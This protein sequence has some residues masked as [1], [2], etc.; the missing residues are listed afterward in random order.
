ML[1]EKFEDTTNGWSE[2][3]N[4][5][6]ANNTITKRKRTNIDLQNTEASTNKNIDVE[7]TYQLIKWISPQIFVITRC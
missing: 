6:R 2:A 4:Q 1:E 3:A 5:R 7:R